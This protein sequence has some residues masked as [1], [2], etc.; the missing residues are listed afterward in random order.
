MIEA[1][2]DIALDEPL[3]ASPFLGDLPQRRVATPPLAEAVGV[4]A[5]PWFVI[6]IEQEADGFLH[7][8]I[9]PRGQTERALLAVFLRDVRPPRRRPSVGFLAQDANDA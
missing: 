1:A 6:G 8:L 2:F 7:E 5:E 3:H 9:R 4:V